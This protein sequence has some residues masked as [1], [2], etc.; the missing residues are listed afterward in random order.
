MLEKE[1]EQKMREKFKA[2]NV[3]FVKF[4]SPSLVGVPDRIV[5][6]PNGRIIFVELKRESGVISPLQKHVHKLLREHHVDVRVII[7][8]EQ[9]MDFVKEICENG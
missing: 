3:I 2:Q 7:G 9:A 6:T 1:I 4:I 8:L 5:I